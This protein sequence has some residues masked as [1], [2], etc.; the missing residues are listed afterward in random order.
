M[1]SIGNTLTAKVADILSSAPTIEDRVAALAAAQGI[2]MR[3]AALHPVVVQHTPFDLADKSLQARYPAIYVYCDKLSNTLKE[4]FRIFSG[5]GH[6]Q[7]EVRYSQDR[8]EEIDA[9][10]QLYVEAVCNVLDASRGDWGGGAFYTGGYE[11]VFSPVR[12]GGHNFLE[13]AKIGLEVEI[14]K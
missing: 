7:I 8:L 11:A 13:I 2:E 9:R 12:A 1:A 14:S 5:K 4:K 10:M 3:P 6:L